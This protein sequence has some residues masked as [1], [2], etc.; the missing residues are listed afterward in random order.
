MRGDNRELGRRG[1]ELAARH[2]QDSGFRIV[3]RNVTN[4]LGEL[5]IV[6]LDGRT[7]VIVEVKT[8][9]GTAGGRRPADAVDHRKRRKLTQVATLFLRDPQWRDSPA[10]F[11]VVEVVVN[12]AGGAPMLRHIRHAFEAVGGR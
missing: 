9:S 4:S 8:R 5:D 10:R 6:A 2:L 3:G 12:P 11:D 7:V 1:E